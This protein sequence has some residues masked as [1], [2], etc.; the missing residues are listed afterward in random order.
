M[1]P[2]I[3]SESLIAEY[4]VFIDCGGKK[5][6]AYWGNVFMRGKSGFHCY[7]EF[8]EDSSHFETVYSGMAPMQMRQIYFIIF[9][10]MD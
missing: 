8:F 5:V 3:K 2:G 9:F 1:M 4:H 7:K 6:S 10:R